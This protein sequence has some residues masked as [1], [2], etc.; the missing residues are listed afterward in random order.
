ML[1]NVTVGPSPRTD[2]IADTGADHLA[3]TSCSSIF[4]TFVQITQQHSNVTPAA[5]PPAEVGY[6]NETAR[7][8]QH[9]LWQDI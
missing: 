7:A 1:C 9:V 4:R 3:T 6:L 8:Q 2:N 5:A